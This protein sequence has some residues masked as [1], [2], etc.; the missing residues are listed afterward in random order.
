MKKDVSFNFAGFGHSPARI[1][2]F[3]AVK[4]THVKT[5]FKTRKSNTV[6]FKRQNVR[7]L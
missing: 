3:S 2:L 6:R 5:Q 4:G 1:P 7:N